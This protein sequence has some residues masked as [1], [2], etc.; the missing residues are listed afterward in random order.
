[1][2]IGDVGGT[3]IRL[4]LLR[5]FHADPEMKRCVILKDL[6]T[7]NPQVEESF[8]AAANKFLKN[9]PAENKPT[10]GVIGMAGAVVNNTVTAVNINH[11]GTTDGK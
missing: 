9:V 7:F 4:K 1:M 6:C 5:L 8:L 2:L 10:I 11:W 3:N